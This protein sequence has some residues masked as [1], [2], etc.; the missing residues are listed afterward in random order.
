LHAKWPDYIRKKRSLQDDI[1]RL[2]SWVYP[3]VGHVP[4]AKFTTEHAE[5]VLRSLPT[6]LSSASRRHVAQVVHRVLKLA[7]YPAKIISASPLPPGFL[8]KL[9]AAKASQYLYPDEDAQLLRA[10]NS[11][12]PLAYRVLFAFL[13]REGVRA[14]EAQRLRWGDLDLDRG[15]IAL[16]ENKTDDPQSWALD[17][18]VSRALCA[19][20][21][22]R[23]DASPSEHVFIDQYGRPI[24]V[25]GL[26]EKFRS[27]LKAASVRRISQP[28]RRRTG[29][30]APKS[31]SFTCSRYA[32]SGPPWP[33]R[34]RA[35][36]VT[37]SRKRSSAKDGTSRRPDICSGSPARKSTI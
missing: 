2:E 24:E 31:N 6:K 34:Y 4:I 20:R 27:F 7:V 22:M 17:P 28:L 12:V 18:G 11:K 14:G 15:A 32:T 21:D 26:A 13:D 35:F 29:T 10:P 19:W 37:I 16:D 36:S 33:K 3:V 30:I 23:D 1:D 25:D 8:P 5:V 9:G